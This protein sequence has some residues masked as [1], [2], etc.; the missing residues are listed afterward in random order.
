MEKEIFALDIGTRKVMGII[1]RQLDDA[2][3]ILD[4]EAI[5]HPSRPMFDGQIHNI[6]EVAKTVRRLKEIL[7]SRQ[8]KP[9]G[10]ACLPVRQA[11]L[12]ARQGG[13]PNSRSHKPEGNGGQP[14]SR[15][16]KKL[17]KGSGAG[18]GRKLF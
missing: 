11:G 14:N 3:E 1:A 2:I 8:N 10:D 15:S 12:P 4:V 9:Q 17:E 5:E 18:V 7:E 16:P 13:Q 6:E